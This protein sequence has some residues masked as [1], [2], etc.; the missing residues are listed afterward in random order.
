MMNS[1]AQTAGMLWHETIRLFWYVA[2]AVTTLLVGMAEGNILNST[3]ANTVEK[4]TCR[5]LVRMKSFAEIPDSFIK[6]IT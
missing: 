2:K 5:I 6:D 1:I 3:R 4:N